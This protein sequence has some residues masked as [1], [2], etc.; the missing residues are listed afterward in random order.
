MYASSHEIPTLPTAGFRKLNLKTLEAFYLAILVLT[1][2][3]KLC[4]NVVIF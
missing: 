3:P 1:F 4:V 2:Y